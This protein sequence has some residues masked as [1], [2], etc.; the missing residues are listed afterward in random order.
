HD[1]EPRSETSQIVKT[2][3]SEKSTASLPRVAEHSPDVPVVSVESV[4]VSGVVQSGVLRASPDTLHSDTIQI[5]TP[6]VKLEPVGRNSLYQVAMYEARKHELNAIQTDLRARIRSEQAEIRQIQ[7]GADAITCYQVF[8]NNT[9]KIFSRPYLSLCSRVRRLYE[10]Q[11]APVDRCLTP[12]APITTRNSLDQSCVW[13][14][15]SWTRIADL[16]NSDAGHLT[17][18]REVCL[19]GD[20]DSDESDGASSSSLS[21]SGQSSAA[22][23]SRQRTHVP[24]PNSGRSQN[25]TPVSYVRLV[26]HD[27][28]RE[29]NHDDEG[30]IKQPVVRESD[31]QKD[32]TDRSGTASFAKVVVGYNSHMDSAIPDTVVNVVDSGPIEDSKEEEEEEEEDDDEEGEAELA[33]TLHQL[34]L[35]NAR[36]FSSYAIFGILARHFI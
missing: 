28:D 6:E 26:D 1:L 5:Q 22:P 8:K 27:D 33:R 29:G 20:D 13:L 30:N 32:A 7:L 23:R 2:N 14:A 17:D 18:E 31:E 4:P 19:I 12:G 21:S 34:T 25:H 15:R 16:L 36:Y 35:D 24:R 9:I 10:A 3:D 11:F